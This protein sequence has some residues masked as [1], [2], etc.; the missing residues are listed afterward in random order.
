[1]GGREGLCERACR[2][3]KLDDDIVSH[4]EASHMC[5]KQDQHIHDSVYR[6]E[7]H[8]LYSI[9]KMSY[10]VIDNK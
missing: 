3:G 6:D 2:S 5:A 10:K 8:K 7:Y 9:T 1:M 4:P